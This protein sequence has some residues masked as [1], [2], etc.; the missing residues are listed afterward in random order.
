[1]TLKRKV[2]DEDNSPT[3]KKSRIGAAAD[4][5]EL[6]YASDDSADWKVNYTDNGKPRAE[7]EARRQWNYV[8]PTCSQRFNRPCRLETH[9]RSHNKERPFACTELGCDKTFPRKDHLQR[10]LKN[11]HSDPETERTFVCDWKDC[12]KSFTSNGRLQRHR[13]VHESKFYCTE[14]PPCSES[15]R[16]AKV[17]EA[18]VK[19]QHLGVKPYVCAHVDEKTGQKCASG[20]QTE[21]ALQRHVH[22]AHNEMQEQGHFCMLCV[23]TDGEGKVQTESADS[24]QLPSFATKE[25][26][27]AHTTEC[28]PPVCTEC[29]QKFKNAS[30][31][32]AH[33]DTVHGDPQEQP[34]YPCPRLGCESVFN[35]KHNLTVH[36]Q[37]VHDRQFKYVCTA[38]AVQN[39]KHADLKSW[40]GEDACGALFKA[41]SS[42]DQHIRKQHLGLGNRK[43]R[44]QAAKSKKKPAA[45]MLTM[46]TGVGYEKDRE[47]PC[48]VK[49]CAYRFY[50]DRDLRRHLRAE[51]NMQD[52][53]IEE[54]ILERDATTGGQFWIGGIDASTNFW[55]DSATPSMPETPGPYFTN[56][57][58]TPVLPC[59]EPGAKGLHDLGSGGGVFNQQFDHLSL[60]NE[61]AEMDLGM[62]L[63]GLPPAVDVQGELQWD[64]LAP[65][66]QYNS[67]VTRG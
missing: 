55:V 53:E 14:Y 45:S 12:G 50:L 62:G 56:S 21:G 24:I 29:G 30:T 42:L 19:S 8:C 7:S 60:A 59:L 38:E 18:H 43:E 49:N 5:P 23:G 15:F 26:L 10:H 40:N 9:M 17:L 20:F 44:R 4:I 31:L 57:T 22:K 6:D 39:S 48:L 3:T 1:M 64:M 32:K 2:T 34:Q 13:G 54:R 65:V 67:D 16:K 36:I 58:T 27:E 33:F 63:G 52:E 66:E 61:E 11:A 47:V 51:H 37:S 28:H 25:E 35:R 41:K 46:L